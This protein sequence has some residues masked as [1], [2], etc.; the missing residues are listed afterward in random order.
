MKKIL[1]VLLICLLTLSLGAQTKKQR[2]AAGYV[3][4]NYEVEC[5]GVGVDGTQLVKVWSFGTSPDKAMTQARK[6]AVHA[7]IFK[8]VRTGL[9]G[10]MMSPLITKPGAEVQH[11]EFFN[12]FFSDGGAYLRFVNQAGDGSID[13]IKIS[14]KSYKVGMV[15]SV[16]HAQLRSELEAAG[17]IPKLGQGF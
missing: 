11:A 7:V 1:S 2:Q 13:R 5:M 3:I 12:N 16:L 8:G 14:N 6:N 4:G 9:P 17:I 10:C 15:V